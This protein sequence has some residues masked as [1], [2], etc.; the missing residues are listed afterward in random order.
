MDSKILDLKAPK[1]KARDLAQQLEAINKKNFQK[2]TIIN[3]KQ[4][5]NK[6]RVHVN[7]RLKHK[8]CKQNTIINPAVCELIRSNVLE[9]GIGRKAAAEAFKVSIRQVYRIIQEDPN[10]KKI[11]QK[12]PGKLTDEMVT[13]LLVFIEEKSTST[14]KEMVQFLQTTFSV[15]VSTQTISNLV[16]DLDVTWKQSTNI[17]ASWNQPD[18]L[19]QR[20]N[21]VGHQGLDLERPVGFVD[22]SGF[23]LHT[24]R[25]H[26]YA[27][28]G[29]P[30]VLS[31][32]PKVKQVT[33]ISA[34]SETGYVY[35]EIL[36]ADDKKTA[37]VGAN[38]FCL[39][40]NS[41]GSR[42]ANDS[43]IIIDN[44]A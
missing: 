40:L 21:F 18:L 36:N 39:C 3:A 35:H 17:P 10:Q 7:D 2:R 22:E 42:L 11:N 27:P 30:S 37:G 19:V 33:L 23:D 28:S 6:K 12:R 15:S 16:G 20:A 1:A 14:Q 43:I 38:N 32:V 5:L 8:D 25:S 31:L 41:L 26:G 44:A 34:I 24:G 4:N 29:Q 9:K 13:S